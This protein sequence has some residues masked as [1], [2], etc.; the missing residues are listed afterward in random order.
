VII[1]E[2]EPGDRFYI[3]VSGQARASSDGNPLR[4]MGAEDVITARLQAG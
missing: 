4:E 1:A 3:T 2:G